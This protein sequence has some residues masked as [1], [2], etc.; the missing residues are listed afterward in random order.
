MERQLSEQKARCDAV[1]KRELEI[2]QTEERKHGEEIQFLKRTNQQLKVTW[3]PPPR[4]NT[5]SLH[6]LKKFYLKRVMS[7]TFKLHCF[8]YSTDVVVHVSI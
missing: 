7:F 3:P 8:F 1:E 5:S 2:R 4:F 6:H